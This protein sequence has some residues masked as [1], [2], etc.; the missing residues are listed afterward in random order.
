MSSRISVL[1]VPERIDTT[2]ATTYFPT[3]DNV[4]KWPEPRRKAAGSYRTTMPNGTTVASLVEVRQTIDGI[5]YLLVANASCSADSFWLPDGSSNEYAVLD[6]YV[7]M[8]VAVAVTIRER[9]GD[10]WCH[11]SRYRIAPD[12][13]LVALPYNPT[14]EELQLMAPG[15]HY[16]IEGTFV[17]YFEVTPG[18]SEPDTWS[19]KTKGYIV[20][21]TPTGRLTL[22]SWRPHMQEPK[23]ESGVLENLG[24][25]PMI[26]GETIRITGFIS[27][28][29]YDQE[30]GIA[31][32][33]YNHP[34]LVV[35]D[36]HRLADYNRLRNWVADITRAMSQHIRDNSWP[37]ARDTFVLMRQQELTSDES[38]EIR[39]LMQTVPAEERSIYSSSR[40]ESDA[41]AKAFGID[42]ETLNRQEFLTY[43]RE[44]LLGIRENKPSDHGRADQS[45][46]FR[47]WWSKHSILTPESLREL[48]IETIDVRLRRLEACSNN[49]DEY[50]DDEYLLERCLEYDSHSDTPHHS[51]IQAIVKT[52][53]YCI[54]KGYFPKQADRDNRVSLHPVCYI[55]SKCF[56]IIERLMKKQR[57]A[58]VISSAQLQSW[59]AKLIEADAEHHI[60]TQLRALMH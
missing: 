34:Y 35:P 42:P 40:Y 53:D 39:A 52:A 24:D 59:E 33:G 55:L 45:Y 5:P 27:T 32:V 26:P 46:I 20:I 28:R 19:T 22:N 1:S 49:L 3:K 30:P 21:D 8:M 41:I 51:M 37:L 6:D 47:F 43:A 10:Q 11:G 44:I 14:V 60:W 16:V 17:E 13:L 57:P 31:T 36:A 56:D 9:T 50:W 48:L 38:R 12:L 2:D 58:D 54:D 7:G 15:T 18:L 29:S 23:Y 25:K 4:A